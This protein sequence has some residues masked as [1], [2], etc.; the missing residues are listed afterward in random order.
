[1]TNEELLKSDVD[2]FIPAAIGNVFTVENADWIQADIVVEDANEQTISS[3]DEILDN[4]GIQV[5]P[6]MLANAG[7]VTVSYFK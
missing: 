3:G 1:M 7:D 5:V 2:I 6:I 4:R